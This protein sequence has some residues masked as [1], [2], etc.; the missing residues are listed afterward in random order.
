LRERTQAPPVEQGRGT[1]ILVLG[2]LSI[3]VAGLL[4]GITAWIMG[5]N[6][7]RKI[8]G[9][10][11]PEAERGKTAAGMFLGVLGTFLRPVALIAVIVHFWNR[12]V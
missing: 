5:S 1:T 8:R 4:F 11:M 6:D 3:V 12:N 10:R 2:I 9:G 7:L